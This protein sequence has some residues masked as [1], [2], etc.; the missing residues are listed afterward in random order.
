MID[1]GQRGGPAKYINHP[2]GP[3]CRFIHEDRRVFII[4]RKETASDEVEIRR[5]RTD[6]VGAVEVRRR[7]VRL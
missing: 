7:R 6:L 2:C 1:A 5:P 3:N 4:V